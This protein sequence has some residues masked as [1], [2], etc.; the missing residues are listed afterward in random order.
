M[1]K[2]INKKNVIKNPHQGKGVIE[3]YEILSQEDMGGSVKVFSK[4]VM[5]SNSVIGYH[6][7]TGE[8]EAYYI[9]KGSGIFIDEKEKKRYV[10]AGDVCLIKSGESHGMKN[11]NDKDMEIIAL[12]YPT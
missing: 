12:V 8:S 7:H 9:L 2:K 10:K 5:K 4:V 3:I 11:D 1:I 6:K